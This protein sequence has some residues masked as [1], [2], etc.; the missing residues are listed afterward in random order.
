MYNLVLF[1]DADVQMSMYM[2]HPLIYSKYTLFCKKYKIVRI[3]NVELL[4]QTVS[5]E[6]WYVK[7]VSD[8]NF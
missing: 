2:Q 3:R 1:T 5:L 6:T 4:I 8:V 7:Y